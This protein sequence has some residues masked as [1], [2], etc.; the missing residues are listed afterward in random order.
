MQIGK[1]E[2]LFIGFLGSFLI[3][4]PRLWSRSNVKVQSSV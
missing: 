4:R 1:L 3:L 2:C